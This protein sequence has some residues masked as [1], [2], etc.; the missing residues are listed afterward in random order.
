M[1]YGASVRYAADSGNGLRFSAYVDDYKENATYGMIIAPL[2]YV[3]EYDLTVENL[4]GENAVYDWAVRNDNGE[5]IYSGNKRRIINVSYDSLGVD[6]ETVRHVIHGSITD[7]KDGNLGRNF[8]GRAY[9]ELNGEY[10]MAEWATADGET[11]M[12]NS[13]RSALEVASAARLSG[14]ELTEEQKAVLDDYETRCYEVAKYTSGDNYTLWFTKT[15]DDGSGKT[16]VKEEITDSAQLPEG[17]SKGYI[18]DVNYSGAWHRIFRNGQL[19]DYTRLKFWIKGKYGLPVAGRLSDGET[20]WYPVEYVKQSNGLWYMYYNDKLVIDNDT[21]LD[22]IFSDTTYVTD[23]YGVRDLRDSLRTVTY[24]SV[25]DVLHTE[26]VQKGN[27]AKYKLD[28]GSVSDGYTEEFIWVTENGGAVEADL[29]NITEDTVVYSGILEKVNKVKATK[30]LLSSVNKYISPNADGNIIFKIK[31]VG[32]QTNVSIY[33]YNENNL[34]NAMGVTE[35]RWIV[36]K[37]DVANN[38]IGFYEEDGTVIAEQNLSSLDVTGLRLSA[39]DSDSADIAVVR[40]PQVKV[41]YLNGDGTIIATVSIDKGGSGE[42]S[43][44]SVVGDDGYT[45]EYSD[46]T[47]LVSADGDEADLSSVKADVT[48]YF[49]GDKTAIINKVKATKELLSSV[50]KYIVPDADGNVT[51]KIKIVGGQTNVSIYDYNEN[52]LLNAMGVTE[53]RWIVF[54]TDVATNKIGFYEEDGTVIAEQNLSSLDVTGLRLSANDSDSADISA[55]VSKKKL[56]IA[57]LVVYINDKYDANTRPKDES[58]RMIEYAVDEFRDLYDMLNGTTL[59]VIYVTSST[60]I[61]EGG[62]C[63]VLGDYLANEAGFGFDALSTDTGYSIR[64][65]NGKVYLYGRTGFGTLNAVYGFFKEVYNLEFYTDEVFTYNP[66][67]FGYNRLEETDFNP[68]IEYNWASGTLEYIEKGAEDPNYAYQ[69]R[70][71]FVNPWQM[72]GGDFHNYFTILPK[73]TYEEAH[74]EWYTTG[75]T[76]DGETFETLNLAY[77]L[78]E[79]DSAMA[80]AVAKYIYDDVV[81]EASEN[82]VKPVWLFGQPDLRGWSVSAESQAIKEKYGSNS[83]E[84]VLFVKKVAKILDDEYTIGRKLQILTMAYNLS[85][86]APTKNL[87]DLKFYNGDEISMGLTFAPIESNLYRSA[88]DETKGYSENSDAQNEIAPLYEK[89]NAYY[90]GQLGEWKKLLNG[91][92]IFCFYYSAHYD[93]YF[94]PMD[95]ISNMQ[96]KYAA[97]ADAGVKHTYNLGQRGGSVASDWTVLKIY[98]QSKY[99]ENAYRTDLETLISNFCDAYYGKAAGAAMKRALDKER[100]QYKKASEYWVNTKGGDPTGC[101]LIRKYLFDKNAWGGDDNG[102]TLLAIYAEI[103]TALSQTEENSEEWKRIKVEGITF[104]YLLAGVYGNTTKGTMQEIASDAKSL[105]IEIFAEGD[106]YTATAGASGNHYS[107]SGKID[108]LA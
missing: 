3:E 76:P 28:G 36:F 43:V 58:G 59:N 32:G 108:D 95:S 12:K 56:K 51:F 7:I 98:L 66:T 37:T 5:W 20:V 15:V 30:E 92:D 4:F 48:V 35:G 99:A 96:S 80:K 53:G 77:G 86:D 70:L 21:C 68:T 61:P 63:F 26:Y 88:T 83:A 39:N 101:H 8:V 29:S 90:W 54:K 104:R 13:V 46:A 45:Y 103:E 67:K 75:R 22:I 18:L 23:L 10:T 40:L 100:A 79:T 62:T 71:G 74:P 9:E 2:D 72:R 31:I 85:F 81:A 69:R 52:N 38:K 44:V 89:S 19:D 60:E 57:S 42:R 49:N 34:L 73:E 17:V 105:G 91:G 14:K 41:T 102:A 24:M 84:S 55:V 87:E 27:S 65:A 1:K 25:D 93:N 82:R 6:G 106:A 94:A 16:E 97:L 33:D 11:S 107:N 50:N 47:W 78:T 64:K